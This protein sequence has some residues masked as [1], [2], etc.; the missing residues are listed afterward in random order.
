M[1]GIRTPFRMS[2]I[3]GGSDLKEFYS[4]SP[5]CVISTTINKYMY[6]F[7]HPFFDERI[8]V[9][10][11]KT[12]L[13]NRVEEIKHP[14]V[15]EVVKKFNLRGIDINS[16]AD[17]PS[18]TGLGSSSSF[19][20]GLLHALYAYT[21]KYVSAEQLARDACEIEIE[22]LNEPIGKQDQ[23]ASAYGGFNIIRFYSDGNVNI[24]PIIVDPLLVE[25][26]QN[27]LLLFYI[28]SI[29]NASSVLSDQK[30]NIINDDEKFNTLQEMTNLVADMNKC[31]VESDLNNFGKILNQNWQLKKSLSPKISATEIDNIYE[32]GLK[33]GASGGKLLG[34]GGGGF[35]LFYCEKKYQ[36][37]LRNSL[38]KLKELRFN[39]EKSGS[40]VIY[41]GDTLKDK[42]W[43]K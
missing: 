26:L 21:H 3:G 2:F 11:S 43:Q 17:I 41:I 9:K 12:E 27:N 20:V 38:S 32:T 24:E 19:T 36:H 34:A 1:I 33:N 40:K 5:G 8:Q 29:R 39:L 22:K 25:T 15:R 35:I 30:K 28:G 37:K 42:I 31:L 6:I 13:V 16:I 23:Y 4:R 10:Y 18:G 7:I 14:I